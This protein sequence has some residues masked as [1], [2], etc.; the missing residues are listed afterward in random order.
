MPRKPR[1]NLAGYHNI[2]NRGVNRSNIFTDE[3][4]YDMFLKIVCKACR[5]QNGKPFFLHETYKF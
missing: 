2:I 4:D 5:D 1:I 3:Y